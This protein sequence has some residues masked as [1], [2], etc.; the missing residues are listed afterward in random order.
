M[1][2][3]CVWTIFFFHR[4]RMT[5]EHEPALMQTSQPA[6]KKNKKNKTLY[7]STPLNLISQYFS[8]H[9]VDNEGLRTAKHEID[10]ARASELH[11]KCAPNGVKKYQHVELLRIFLLTSGAQ[12]K[13]G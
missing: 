13:L 8:D 5:H 11:L 4:T 1:K 9:V 12:T 10:A 2:E 6:R 7:S 3:A